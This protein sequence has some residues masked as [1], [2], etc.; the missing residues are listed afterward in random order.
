MSFVQIQAVSK[1]FSKRRLIGKDSH[2]EALK[3]VSF[4]IQEGQT[5][6]LV[7]ESVPVNL[8]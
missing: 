6:A 7:G 1:T 5:Y 3:N 2:V 4:S 8:P